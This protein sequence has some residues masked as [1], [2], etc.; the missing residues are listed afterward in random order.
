MKPRDCPMALSIALS[1]FAVVSSG[2]AFAEAPIVKTNPLRDAFYGDLHLHTSYSFDAYLGGTTRVDPDVA[3]KFAKGMDVDYLGT[4]VRRR[5]AL[6]FLAVTDHGEN[7]G[8]LSELEDPSS[9]VSRSDVGK[10]LQAVIAPMRGS[11][12]R[13]DMESLAD[14][15]HVLD[16][17]NARAQDY[18]WGRKNKLPE[19]LKPESTAA[20][21]REIEFANRNYEPGRFTTFIA[22]E[23]TA[24]P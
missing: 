23:W 13:P 9:R 24:N 6:D 3:Y 21:A 8:V 14:R 11:D 22:Y 16:E 2:T 18:A 15:R 12:G 17:L 1:L 5:E 19:E 4:S 20:W 10:V 7:I